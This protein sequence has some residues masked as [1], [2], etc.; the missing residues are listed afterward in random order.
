MDKKMVFGVLL[1]VVGLFFSA[2]CFIDAVLNPCV[3]NGVDGLLG[4]F[5][6]RDTLIA[7]IISL[8]VMIVGLVVCFLRA[9]REKK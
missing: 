2:F 6:G 1:T 7:F 3:Y 5:Y 9:F 4:A 8:V